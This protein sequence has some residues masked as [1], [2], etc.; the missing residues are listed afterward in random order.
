MAQCMEQEAVVVAEHS[1]GGDAPN[2]WQGFKSAQVFWSGIKSFNTSQA[3]GRSCWESSRKSVNPLQSSDIDHL[4]PNNC[5]MSLLTW[6][7]S[8]DYRIWIIISVF[9]ESSSWAAIPLS[10]FYWQSCSSSLW[11]SATDDKPRPS[12][13]FIVNCSSHSLPPSSSCLPAT[14]KQ[15]TGFFS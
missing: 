7:M 5:G 9:W 14:Y 12:K 15:S 6:S 8:K 1:L 11:C 4:A 2:L 13:Y 3:H 10:V